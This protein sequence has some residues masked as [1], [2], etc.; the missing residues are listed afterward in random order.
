M[1]GCEHVHKDIRYHK[2]KTHLPCLVAN[3]G[4]FYVL[5]LFSANGREFIYHSGKILTHHE[6]NIKFQNIKLLL[7]TFIVNSYKLHPGLSSKSLIPDVKFRVLPD[8]I[9]QTTIRLVW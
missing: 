3:A 6:T 2:N 9:I 5:L 1:Y 8:L 4:L 7:I